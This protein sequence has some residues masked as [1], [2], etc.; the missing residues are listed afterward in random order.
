MGALRRTSSVLTALAAAS[1]VLGGCA[2]DRQPETSSAAVVT[3]DPPS[4]SVD[5]SRTQPGRDLD[6]HAH[7]TTDPRSIWVVVNKTHPITPLTFRPQLSIVRGYQV[8]TP[9]AGPLTD[10]LAASDSAG[11]GFKI[12]SAFRSFDYQERVHRNL[13][14]SQGQQAADRVSARPGYS[15]HQTGL[16]VD[17][18]TPG[19]PSCDFDQCFAH[20]PGGRWL[21]EHAWEYG[22]LVRYTPRNEAVTGYE[23]EPW[24]LRYVGKPLATAM[25]NAGVTT[26]EEFLGVPGG[27]YPR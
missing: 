1:L 4:R 26:L 7:S 24:H 18:I 12:A 19:S 11:L 15:E 14:A 22:F 5:A 23:P 2:A 10:L 20:T 17:L 8:A 27:D 16:A 6:T 3:P 25:H 9:A 13:V 21:T